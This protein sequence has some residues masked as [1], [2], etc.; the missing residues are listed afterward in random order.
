MTAINSSTGKISSAGIGSGLDVDSIVKAMVAAEGQPIDDLKKSAATLGGKLSTF[1]TVKSYLSS[2][3]DAAAKLANVTS[4][5]ATAG[6][7]SDAT[8]VAISSTSTAVAGSYSVG[9]S[10]LAKSQSVAS[11]VYAATTDPV[12]A[13]MLRVEI[14]RWSAAQAGF[15]ARTDP[16]GVDI[17]VT[18]TDTLASV[19]DKIN[20]ADAG[21]T[22][23]IL[24]DSAGARLVMR[25]AD[26]G[27][28]N[29][30][31]ITAT[32][33]DGN[34]TDGSGLSALAYDPPSGTTATTLS[35][36]AQDAKATINGLDI[37]SASN[38][39]TNVMDG[40]SL[41]LNA[42]TATDSPVQLTV[43][44]DTASM[45]TAVQGFVDSYNQLMQYLATQTKY[46]AGTK[47]AGALQGD[48]TAN[49]IRTQLRQM[50]SQTLSSSSTFTRVTDLGFDLQANGTI[51]LDAS[52]LDNAL[53]NVPEMKKMFSA[54]NL[55]DS[56]QNG[57]GVQLRE[58]TDGMLGVDGVLKS[59]TEGIQASIDLNEK[60]QEA[61]QLRVD[62][63]EKRVRAQYTA[64]DGTMSQMN[65]LSTY[66]TQQIAQM[67]KSSS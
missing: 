23:V 54:T 38:A 64:L 52:K 4:W 1:G 36:A 7:S 30:F 37:T 25:S 2:F 66:L 56:T 57:L 46:D 21:V 48:S 67:N 14:G 41:T 27:E 26:T 42:V 28:E 24:N 65:S 51:K 11:S 39:L 10:Q 49:S 40:V 43:S 29:G 59:R 13:G 63:F 61:M 53:K 31:R 50:M 5:A 16:P 22:A 55:A 60:R 6:S 15:T 17:Q 19:R 47:T 44:N 12:G 20:A 62:A 35:T 8:K 45:K 18:A 3:R 9:V 32:D 58:L 33:T 34:N